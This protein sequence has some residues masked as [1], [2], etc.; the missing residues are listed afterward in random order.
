[1]ALMAPWTALFLMQS[2]V[3]RSMLT[4][5][6]QFVVVTL[7]TLLA[8]AA[9]ALTHHA[10]AAMALALP[11]T[12]LIGSYARFGSQGF[13]A[14]TAALFVLA[15]GS[16]TSADIAH[17]LLETLLG[18]AVGIS[19][20]ALVLPPVHARRVLHLHRQ[21]RL[22]SAQLLHT[23][24]DGISNGR[25][26]KEA[27]SWSAGARRL[28]DVT[29]DLQDARRWMDESYRVNPGLHLRRQADLVPPP[30][31]RDFAW[32]Q[33]TE[34]LASVIRTLGTPAPPVPLA[35][36]GDEPLQTLLRAAGDACRF[37]TAT[38]QS[39]GGNPGSVEGGDDFRCSLARASAAH[40]R[41][42]VAYSGRGRVLAAATEGL[43]TDTRRLLLALLGTKLPTDALA[44]PSAAYPREH[45]AS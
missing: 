36:D 26:A 33:V 13:A 14:P 19:V 25:P 17:R 30:A 45:C 40:R 39:A 32:T 3:Y 12:V 28:A 2:T 10:M 44:P 37:A 15:Y 38:V 4:A 23:V 7:G 24:A 21:L 42:T 1:M 27:Q 18:A 6:Q 41:L 11:L 31:Q 35:P 9:G 29:A 43:L 16:Y 5:L 8:A 20:N 34:H 22:S